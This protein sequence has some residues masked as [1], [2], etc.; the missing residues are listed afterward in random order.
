MQLNY[1]SFGEGTPVVILHGLLGSLDNWQTFA[2]K[3]SSDFKVFTIDLRNHGRSPHSDEHSYPAMV[4]DLVEFFTKHHIEDAHIIGH[5]MGGK[6][7]MQFAI[8]H[9]EKVLKLIVVDIAP[10]EYGR[11]H[12]TIFDALE[13]VDIFR[14]TKRDDA[15]AMLATHIDDF[16]VR[17]FLLKNLDR[18]A[19]GSFS[20]KMNL[21]GLIRNYEQINQAIH[22]EKPVAVSAYIIRGGKSNYVLENDLSSFQK[23]FPKIELITIPDAGH[24]VHAETPDVFYAAVHK[25]LADIV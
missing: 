10:K 21:D 5:S 18:N 4:S 9:S 11:G 25:I 24:W 7:A 2:R 23:I 14:I 20:W 12:D 8:T 3:L 13:D 19:D 16:A 17:Q 1:K 6:V 15:D 22:S